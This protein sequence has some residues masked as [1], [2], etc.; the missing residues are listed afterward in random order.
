MGATLPTLTRYLS[1]GRSADRRGVQQLYAANTIGAILGTAIAGFALI[2]LLGLSGRTGGRRGVLGDRGVSGLWLA[3]KEGAPTVASRARGG[4]LAGTP[5]DRPDA[6]R[7][8]DGLRLGLTSLGYQTLW[9]RMLASGT[10]NTTYVFT[11]ILAMFLGGL[12]VGALL[13][14][15]IR[16]WMREPGAFPG[17]QP[18]AGRGARPV[19]DGRV[20][21]E[22]ARLR[23]RARSS[24]RSAPDRLVCSRRASDH[25]RARPVVPGG[26]GAAR[27]GSGAFRPELRCLPRHEH[28]RCHRR[29]LHR[30]VRAHPDARRAACDR[31]PGARQRGYR[32]SDRA[33]DTGA[34][35]TRAPG[36][37]RDVA[38]DRFGLRRRCRR[39]H[40]RRL[41]DA[42][43]PDLSE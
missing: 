20:H 26:L 19:R 8:G 41:G 15:L 12:A 28:G 23:T 7:A 18:G 40:R 39:R 35:E 6:P 10:G 42:R 37:V 21:R 3:R 27:A 34:I 4:G 30:P 1:R 33:R 43:Y 29:Q 14:T 11:I 17:G 5:V 16:R 25:C 31:A 22:P 36:P 38:P 32:R 9:I 2:E 13:F 24:T